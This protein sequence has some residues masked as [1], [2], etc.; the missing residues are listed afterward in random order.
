MRCAG[1]VACLALA[2]MAVGVQADDSQDQGIA[3][4]DWQHKDPMPKKDDYP[5]KKDDYPHKKDDGYPH[6][7]DHWPPKKGHECRCNYRKLEDLKLTPKYYPKQCPNAPIPKLSDI[8][9]GEICG[10]KVY[11]KPEPYSKGPY[12]SCDPLKVDYVAYCPKGCKLDGEFNALKKVFP[13]AVTIPFG[14]SDVYFKKTSY[15][16]PDAYSKCLKDV[17][18]YGEVEYN[19]GQC[20][21][22][23]KLSGKNACGR[24]TCDSDVSHFKTYNTCHKPPHK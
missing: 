4:N 21:A 14:D 20:S 17:K 22:K 18:V 10:K 3:T 19:K 9:V 2:L 1:A 23:V 8:F 6:K 7:K 13:N 16:C 11:A 15:G 24:S 5:H 12:N